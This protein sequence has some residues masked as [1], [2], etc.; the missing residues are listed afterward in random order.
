MST[1][2]IFVSIKHFLL[3]AKSI[4]KLFKKFNDSCSND[5]QTSYLRIAKAIIAFDQ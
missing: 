5:L 4:K 2:G 1:W 3:E